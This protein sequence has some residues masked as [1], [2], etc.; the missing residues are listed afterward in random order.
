MARPKVYGKR[1][2]TVFDT[3]AADAFSSSP[4]PVVLAAEQ[5][6]LKTTDATGVNSPSVAKVRQPVQVTSIPRCR[7]SEA[8]KDECQEETPR[9]AL[10]EINANSVISPIS[11]T[12]YTTPKIAKKRTHNRSLQTASSASKDVVTA[13]A[14]PSV[15][16]DQQPEDSATLPHV[17]ALYTEAAL[18]AKQRRRE[19]RAAKKAK[20]NP[21]AKTCPTEDN[22]PPL[23]SSED[24]LQAPIEAPLTRLLPLDTASTEIYQSHLEPLLDLSPHSLTPF[25]TWSELLDVHFTLSKIAEASFGEVFRLSYQP[26][27]S[28]L[29]DTIPSSEE[30]VFKIIPLQPPPRTLPRDK[31]RRAAALRK[32]EMMTAPPDVATEVRLL[33]R[34]SVVP[35]FTNFRDVRVTQGQ[36]TGAFVQACQEWDAKQRSLGKDG[37]HFPDPGKKGVYDDGQCWAVIEMQDAGTDLERVLAAEDGESGCKSVWEVWD[38]FWQVVLSLAKGEEGSEFEHRDLHLGNVCIRRTQNDSKLEVDPARNLGFTDIETTI[39][40][41]TISRCRMPDDSIAYMDLS[42][43]NALFE[44]DST[45][46]YQYDIYRYMR[47]VMYQDWAYAQPTTKQMRKSGRTWEQFH[48]QT[49]LVWLHLILYN[50]LE[51]MEW[52]GKKV[53]PSG[54]KK[55]RALVKRRKQLEKILL[56]MQELLDPGEVCGN[57]IW[58]AGDLVAMAVGEGWLGVEDVVGDGVDQTELEHD[59]LVG[60][61]ESLAV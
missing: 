43:D 39:I 38:V 8:R 20:S 52:S 37:S 28:D 36:P 12:T 45:E 49:N 6:M 50:L 10:G 21:M 59:R 44:G 31:R 2:R 29:S 40:D 17:D 57:G 35:G 53:K 22:Q 23:P 15:T 30:S 27:S 16:K 9:K 34:M 19:A 13:H 41:Y 58:A 24:V 55:D 18:E 33:Q 25:S 3:R 14:R 4:E 46:E 7:G 11:L 51:Q 60:Y 48:P 56:R 1:S 61:M 47:G 26:D 42:R 5:V 32:S 54:S